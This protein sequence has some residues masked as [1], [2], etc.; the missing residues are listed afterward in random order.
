MT[1]RT[2]LIVGCLLAINAS[3]S[4]RPAHK[5]AIADYLGP[6]LPKKLNSC[7]LCHLPDAKGDD[8]EKPHNVF[9]ARLAAVRKE[10]Q[11]A[12]KSADVPSRR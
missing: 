3:A 9:G 12:G 2:L 10:L 8:G 6:F 11:R 5:K 4:A 1:G 7:T